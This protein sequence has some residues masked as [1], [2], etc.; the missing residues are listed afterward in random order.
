MDPATIALILSLAGKAAEFGIP[1]LQTVIGMAKMSRAKRL[2]PPST[3]PYEE[4]QL[5]ELE[6]L[7]NNFQS[8]NVFHEM[9]K[10]LRKNYLIGSQAIN[11]SAGGYVGGNIM[12]QRL[13][14]ENVGDITSKAWT[15]SMDN[16][17][18]LQKL[19]QEQRRAMAQRRG[20]ID[21]MRYTQE[22]T[23]GRELFQSGLANLLGKGEQEPKR[24]PPQYMS[25]MP[26]LPFPQLPS[27]SSEPPLPNYVNKNDIPYM[28]PPV[29]SYVDL[30]EG[31][32]VDLNQAALLSSIWSTP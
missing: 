8:G 16:M 7:R 19:L 30:G 25:P 6:N 3:D 22:M 5:L 11:Q 9:L 4:K 28:P 14:N 29:T 23:T 26:E 21:M 17:L 31:T 12:G 32:P 18:Q 10:Q 15:Q 1:I 13:L 20:G 24:M 27:M 2:L